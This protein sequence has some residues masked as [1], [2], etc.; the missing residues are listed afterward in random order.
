[1]LGKYSTTEKHTQNILGFLP[2]RKA[3]KLR[4]CLTANN[5]KF[6]FLQNGKAIQIKAIRLKKKKGAKTV[7]NI[8]SKDKSINLHEP[9]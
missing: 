7:L 4:I 8:S 1:M 2:K 3:G 6:A 9:H 5:D